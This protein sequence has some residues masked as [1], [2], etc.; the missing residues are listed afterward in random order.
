MLRALGPGIH[1]AEDLISMPG[2]FHLPIRMTALTTPGGVVLISPVAIDDTL[3]AEIEAVGPVTHLIAPSRLHHVHLGAAAA[4]WPGARVLGPAGLHTKRPDLRFHGEPSADTPPAW[5]DSI[6]VQPIS[7][8]PA[9]EE[10]AF[11]HRPSRSLVVC[12]LLFNVH[13]TKGWVGPLILWSV[14]AWK[15]PTQSLSW[16]MFT[17]DRAAAR[18]SVEALLAWDFERIVCAHGEIVEGDAKEVL[19]WACRWMLAG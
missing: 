3:A 2:A 4:R 15:K 8:V 10:V 18:A 6:R 5:G 19:R 14:G 13:Q 9:M 12:D 11:L 7:G 16:R 17:K 1:V